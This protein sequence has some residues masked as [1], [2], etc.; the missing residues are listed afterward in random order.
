MFCISSGYQDEQC[1]GFG[2]VG[3]FE[4]AVVL[5]GVGVVSFLSE[6]T[7]CLLVFVLFGHVEAG[8]VVLFGPLCVLDVLQSGER[9]VLRVGELV[10]FEEVRVAESE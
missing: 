1:V 6:A 8:L 7:Y 10:V 5:D 2:D 3:V 4:F 9:R